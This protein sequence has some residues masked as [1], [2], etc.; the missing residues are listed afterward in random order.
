[1]I[2][3]ERV[4]RHLELARDRIRKGSVPAGSVFHIS[5]SW[6]IQE[7]WNPLQATK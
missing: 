1:M 5:G 2:G 3:I 7:T 6:E 4:E